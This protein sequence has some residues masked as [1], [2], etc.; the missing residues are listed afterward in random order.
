ME[1]CSW[2]I[3]NNLVLLKV[4][5]VYLI[6]DRIFCMYHVC[7]CESYI[8]IVMSCLKI[9]CIICNVTHRFV[10]V[11]DRGCLELYIQ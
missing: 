7:A 1:A 6:E 10:F 4:H 2:F 3:R 9:I 11:G 5:W 8:H